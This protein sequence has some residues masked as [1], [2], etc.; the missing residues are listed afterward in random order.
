MKLIIDLVVAGGLSYMRYSISDTA[1]TATTPS[2]TASSRRDQKRDEK[3]SQ[4]DSGRHLCRNWILENQA[5]R[6]AL[7]P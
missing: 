1:D 6:R 7:T 5:N 4:R 3:G 2:A